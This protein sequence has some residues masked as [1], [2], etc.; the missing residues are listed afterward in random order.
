MSGLNHRFLLIENESLVFD[1]F[2][3]YKD[4]DCVQLHDDFLQYFK[5]SIQWISS[6][7]PYSDE[8]LM[9]LCWYGPTIIDDAG[10]KKT[11]DIIE[12]W[13]QLLSLAPDNLELTGSYGWIEG[14]P[15]DQ[16][17]YQKLVFN[18]VDILTELSKLVCY[19]E[20][21]IN[22]NGSKCLLHLGV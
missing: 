1:D 7:N 13:I 10:I 3:V 14:D 19:C 11:R 22:S 17:K 8:S 20:S 21:V 15:K 12:S 18:K 5:D 6:K 16:G 4:C 2:L 9:G